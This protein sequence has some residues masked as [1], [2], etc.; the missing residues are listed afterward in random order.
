MTAFTRIHSRTRATCSRRF[1]GHGST[2]ASTITT[3]SRTVAR[4]GAR[5]AGSS[6]AETS[7]HYWTETLKVKVMGIDCG[8]RAVRDV[9]DDC[10]LLPDARQPE[11]IC[12]GLSVLGM[13]CRK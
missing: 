7:V 3:L 2:P 9:L 6:F 12:P 11:G 10:I 8:F 1:F 4:S 13:A 5:S